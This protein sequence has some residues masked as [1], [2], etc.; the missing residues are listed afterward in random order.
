VTRRRWI[1]LGD[2]EKEG[3]EEEHAHAQAGQEDREKNDAEKGQ[4]AVSIKLRTS[5]TT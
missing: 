1:S 4:Q 2:E 5:T 3:H